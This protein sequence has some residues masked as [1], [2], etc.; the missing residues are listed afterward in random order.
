[1]S[2]HFKG[3]K[4]EAYKFSGLHSCRWFI[5][6][7]LHEFFDLTPT[8]TV[9]QFTSYVVTAV[10]QL[11]V[12]GYVTLR[13]V[14]LC[15]WLDCDVRREAFTT[16]RRRRSTVDA[17]DQ[18]STAW[19]LR[20]VPVAVPAA[21]ATSQGLLSALHQMD[22]P[23]TRSLQ[24]SRLQG[25]LTS[26]G[27]SQEQARHELWNHGPRAQVGLVAARLLDWQETHQQMRY[28]NATSLHFSAPLAFNA[29]G[30]GIPLGRSLY[31]FARRSKDG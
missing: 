19:W 16:G 7:E 24:A 17:A 8:L 30:G 27:S 18:V 13:Y 25:R 12:N 11:L 23:R 10:C 6:T 1:M 9:Y 2:L 26:L 3:L 20:H 4:L 22:G 28:P 15:R 21:A 14:M 5:Y 29:P 31:N